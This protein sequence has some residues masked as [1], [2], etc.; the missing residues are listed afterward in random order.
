MRDVKRI[1]SSI[2][3]NPLSPGTLLTSKNGILW[4][5]S[6]CPICSQLAHL[7]ITLC[8]EYSQGYLDNHG[9]LLIKTT[10]PQYFQTFT[11]DSSAWTR[12]CRYVDQKQC[13]VKTQFL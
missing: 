8:H 12:A 5:K 1:S 11:V 13:E 10:I 6:P 7:L 9:S 2:T 4:E 3:A